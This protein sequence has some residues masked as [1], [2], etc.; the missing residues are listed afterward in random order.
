MANRRDLKKDINHF[1]YSVV[2][3]CYSYL[4]YSP[5][6]HFQDVFDIMVEA[7]NLRNNLIHR[8]N[9]NG[10]DNNQKKNKDHYKEIVNDLYSKNIEFVE[11]L[12]NIN[13]E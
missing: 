2:M 1:F 3:E 7:A 8:V 13:H 10:I 5:D 4:E 12:N 11:R 6:T 9:H